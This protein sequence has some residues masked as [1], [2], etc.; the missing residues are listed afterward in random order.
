MIYHAWR[1]QGLEEDYIY[2]LYRYIYNLPRLASLRTW[3]RL[4]SSS[5]VTIISRYVSCMSFRSPWPNT[6]SV[7]PPSHPSP[8]PPP[9]PRSHAG[10][11][12]LCSLFV[13]T[14][15][16]LH[17]SLPTQK[18]GT[19]WI[20]CMQFHTPSEQPPPKKAKKKK[21]LIRGLKKNI[22]KIQ[23]QT[24]YYAVP[25]AEWTHCGRFQAKNPKN[26]YYL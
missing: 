18:T 5:H 8:P 16:N 10:I 17:S 11:V 26:V 3:G 7:T 21:S 4:A 15:S 24:G 22:K 6:L 23:V 9:P 25:H 14:L 2:N 12:W 20:L 19:N 13:W 1:P